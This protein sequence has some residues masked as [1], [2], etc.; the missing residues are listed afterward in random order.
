MPEK[1]CPRCGLWN[2]AAAMRCDCGYDFPSSA[3]LSPYSKDLSL[4]R[5]LASHATEAVLVFLLLS[6]VAAA[7]AV[8]AGL[9]VG[10]AE[11]FEPPANDGTTALS[12][13]LAYAGIAYFSA[14]LACVLL[15]IPR[16]KWARHPIL[17]LSAVGTVWIVLAPVFIATLALLAL[18]ILV[19]ALL[20]DL[21][22]YRSLFP[23]QA[24][25][26]NEPAA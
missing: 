21:F 3:M 4:D 19:G 23:L 10:S 18:P 16:M 24:P 2:S 20:A 6:M 1:A 22:I 14:S 7:L 26:S 15:S 25:R 17:V 5:Q 8:A 13:F 9:V 12:E 11:S